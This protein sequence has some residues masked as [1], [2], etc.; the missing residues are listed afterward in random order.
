MTETAPNDAPDGE[1]RDVGEGASDRRAATGVGALLRAERERQG[2]SVQD[3]AAALRLRRVMVEALEAGRADRLP[4]ATY[5]VAF[6][7][8][9]CDY[10]GLDR[11]E[12]VA[13]FRHEAEGL[14][15]PVELTFPISASDSRL[16]GGAIVM[17]SLVVAIGA[18]VFWYLG[19]AEF[20]TRPPR[21][22]AVPPPLSALLDRPPPVQ[23]TAPSAQNAVAATIA[24]RPEPPTHAAVDSATSGGAEQAATTAA[25]PP[26]VQPSAEAGAQQ[27]TPVS[28]FAGRIVL[29]ATAD[30]WLRIRDSAGTVLLTRMMKPGDELTPPDREGLSMFIGS[31]GALEVLVDGRRAPALG[32][33]G[34]VRRDV[35]LDPD[36]LLA[37]SADSS[38]PAMIAPTAPT[39][40][41][42][43]PEGGG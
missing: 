20:N 27:A 25:S 16:P 19:N 5:A 2:L 34:A 36:R 22:A 17:V 9:Y 6:V 30:C 31:A 40:R 42:V 37:A 11:D 10:L 32:P 38:R 15:H 39:S 24:N 3:V 21:V 12:I 41:P 1:R 29:R 43:R 14:V 8:S 4:G 33:L 26:I 35:P 28:R 18:Y 23:A 13:R 7:R